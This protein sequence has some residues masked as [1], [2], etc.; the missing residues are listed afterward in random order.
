L[1]YFLRMNDVDEQII[2]R[3]LGGQGI[4]GISRSIK[5]TQTRVR[6][7]I[8]RWSSENMPVDR[9]IAVARQLGRLD[10]LIETVWPLAKSGNLKA[11]TA[12]T[13][14]VG[15]QCLLQGINQPSVPVVNVNVERPPTMTDRIAGVIEQLV[16]EQ[17]PPDGSP[18][19]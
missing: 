8:R 7:A 17:G 12:V 15:A 5:T 3:W 11:I 10:A 1:G 6:E 9:S 14:L 13:K 19:N 4:R 18:P 2:A 16:A